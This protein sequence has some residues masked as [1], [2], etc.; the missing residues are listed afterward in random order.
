[1]KPGSTGWAAGFMIV[2]IALAACGETPPSDQAAP[3]WTSST[4]TEPAVPES[5][6][7]GGT[8]VVAGRGDPV[9]MNSLVSTDFESE[10]HQVHVLFVT[11]VSNDADYEPQPYLAASWEFDS[12]TSEVVF[13][14]RHDLEWHDGTPVTSRDVAFTF[15]RLKNPAVPFPNPSYFDYWD[16]AEVID[17]V[18]IRF[19]LR[20]HA[21]ALYG[22]TRTAIMPEHILGD[23]PP[24]DLESHSFGTMS[25]VGNGP[26]RFVE[27][28][29]GDRWVFEANPGFPKELGGR[30]YVDRLVYRQ[31][32]DE[33]A[34]AA[35]LRTGEVDL[36]IDASPSMLDQVRDDA[37]VISTSYSAPEYAF[38]AWNSRRTE[39]TDPLVRRAL[40]MAIDRET[41]VQVVLGGNGTVAPGPVG[42]WHWA[43]DSAWAPLPYS[44][45]DAAALLDQAGWT[46]SDG[47]GTRDRDGEPFR[48]ELLATP[49]RDWAA[50]QTLVQASLGEIGVEVEPVVREQGA[51]IPLVIGADR[52][53][54]AVIIGWARDVPLNDIDLWACDQVGQ[55]FQF[56]S[57]CNPDLDAVLDAIP[58][59]ADRTRLRSLIG[60]YHEL[61]VADQPYTFLYYVDRVDLARARVYGT[62]MDSRGDWVNVAR[63]WVHDDDGESR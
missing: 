7:Y 59:E 15:D 27:R 52:R 38:I 11:L 62:D 28:V 16:A 47:D 45:V 32:P 57:Y 61:V 36:V 60:R 55:P 22:W 54:D 24:E 29:P 20:P 37:E 1:M 49:R 17:P 12:D 35:A 34:L 39:F 19:F 56:T 50:I 13:R 2:T 30:P 44:S 25:P 14:L 9:S 41:L 51:L 5:E 40:T 48:F 31:I 63:W 8:L 58:L 33:F 3:G 46:D 18:T 42:P 26:F 10:Q 4:R 6:R 43:Y 53:F 21:N 23:V